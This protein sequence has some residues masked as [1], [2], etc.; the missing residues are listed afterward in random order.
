MIS[1]KEGLGVD[2]RVPAEEVFQDGD[3]GLGI[4]E[5]LV[6][7]R[8][9]GFLLYNDIR[10][11]IEEILIVKGD[12][13]DNA[14]PVGHEAELVGIAEMSVDVHLLDGGIG[15]GMGRHG[16]IGSR[17]GGIGIIESLSFFKGLEMFDYAVGVFRVIF[18]HPCF[19]IGDIK[20]SYGG[21]GRVDFLADWLC[22]VHNV[23]EHGLQDREEILLEPREP[24]GV[25]DNAEAAEIPQL[26]GGLAFRKRL[27]SFREKGVRSAAAKKAGTELSATKIIDQSVSKLS[28]QF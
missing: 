24:G 26:C 7:I 20:N 13:A 3:E 28:V 5:R 17:I 14:Q 2:E 11:R 22:Q 15:F 12:A 6:L 8:E 1:P 9:V 23:I 19:D 16:C 4:G 25:R 10:I 21:K 18:C 27:S